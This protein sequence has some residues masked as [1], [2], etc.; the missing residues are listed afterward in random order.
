MGFL[1]RRLY[2]WCVVR[3]ELSV[4]T[5]VVV[6]RRSSVVTVV[7]IGSGSGSDGECEGDGEYVLDGDGECK[8]VAFICKMKEIYMK[9]HIY[10]NTMYM[11]CAWN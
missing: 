5:V 11:C 8:Y 2:L 6:W 1:L 7:V 3:R 10:M 9:V 4:V